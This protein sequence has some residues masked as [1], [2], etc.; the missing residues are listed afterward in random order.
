MDRL[1]RFQGRKMS[2]RT[3]LA[4]IADPT[5]AVW[6]PGYE[7]CVTEVEALAV[8][9]SPKPSTG[10]VARIL[11][12]WRGINPVTLG[13][14]ERNYEESMESFI[15]QA[16]TVRAQCVTLVGQRRTTESGEKINH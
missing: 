16:Q 9:T 12:T 1:D 5:E 8:N 2:I 14:P 15:G 11:A 3:V 6:S 7:S 4:K 10:E 13:Q